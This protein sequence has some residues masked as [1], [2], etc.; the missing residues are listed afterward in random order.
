[1]PVIKHNPNNVKA[2]LQVVRSKKSLALAAPKNWLAVAES[3][4]S[5]VDVFP[6]GFWIKITKIN[7]KATK[8]IETG[9]NTNISCFV[10]VA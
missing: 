1:M 10:L 6:L 3:P 5:V 9:S 8:A 7:K 4:K 2:R